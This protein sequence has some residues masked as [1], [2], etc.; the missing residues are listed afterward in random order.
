MSMVTRD[1]ANPLVER[2]RYIERPVPVVFPESAEVPETQL[3]LD[4]RTLLYHL[5][6]SFLGEQAS[7]GSEQFVYF[8]AADPSVCL[9]P[10]VFVALVPSKERIRTWKVWERGAPVVAVEVTSNSDASELA[11]RDKLMRYQRLGVSELIRFDV[12]DERRPLRVWDRVDGALTE[13]ELARSRAASLVLQLDWV[14]AP[15]DGM[16]RALRIEHRGE[17]VKTEKEARQAEA[18]ARRVAEQRVKELEEEL[19]RRGGT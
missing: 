12:D 14:V 13:R 17:L 9:A 2:P 5:L 11:W 1:P 4:L 7:V 8:D 16:P 6:Q 19:R 15:A 18:E 10:D 3:H